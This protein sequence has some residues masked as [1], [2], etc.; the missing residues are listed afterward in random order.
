MAIFNYT[1]QSDGT[2]GDV[3]DINVPF[4]ALAALLNAGLTLDNITPG[5]LDKSIFAADTK[6]GWT[7][8]AAAPNTVTYN[9]QRSYDLVFNSADYTGTVGLGQRLR[10]TRSVGAPTQCTSLNGT[11]QYYSKATPNKLTFTDDFVCSA[12]VM[13]TSYAQGGIITRYNGTSGWLMYVGGDGRVGLQ[14]L[15][16]GSSNISYVLSFQALPLNKWVHVTAQLD[17]SSFTATTTTSYIMFDGIDVPAQVIRGGTNP[18]A[19]IQAGNL[20]IG[21]FNGGSSPFPGK[22]AQA[23]VFNAKVTQA[24]MRGYISQGLAGTETSLAS[25]YSFNNSITDLNTTTPNDLT[26]NGSATA[27]NADS[28]FANNDGGSY[29]YGIVVAKSYSTNTTLT[30]QVPM[31][32][33]IP[34]SGGVSVAAYSGERIPFGFPSAK[35]KWTVFALYKADAITTIGGTATWVAC[36]H[37]LNVP[38]GDWTVRKQGVLQLSSTVG[39]LRSGH[40]LLIDTTPTNGAY[41]YPL[42]TELYTP[43]SSTF[44]LVTTNQTKDASHAAAAVYTLYVAIDSSTGT[45]TSEV[46]GDL[47]EVLLAAENGYL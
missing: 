18:T 7:A 24:T 10:L 26:A 17:M 28:P 43:G 15:N 3:S 37:K 11:T 33:A 41:S 6:K 35:S 19:L 4:A 1:P 21:S 29:E 5:S 32:C 30:V 20:E 39:G 46:R 44:S 34:T 12:W 38:V 22:I 36:P 23:A 31:G 42:I 27:T 2:V 14:G 9:G 8:L 25:A 45:E 13:L 40:Y 16:T 47:S